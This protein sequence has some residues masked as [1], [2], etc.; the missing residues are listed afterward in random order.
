MITVSIKLFQSGA[1][2]GAAND[3]LPERFPVVTAC[4]SVC[5]ETASGTYFGAVV[6]LPCKVGCSFFNSSP[7]GQ[8]VRHFA[9]DIFRCIFE[10][11]KFCILNKISMKFVPK[12][13]I[14]N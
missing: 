5:Q 14:D 1:S 13:L 10:N 3:L 6:C 7:P 8:D 12:G 9:D 11:E 4:C 2:V